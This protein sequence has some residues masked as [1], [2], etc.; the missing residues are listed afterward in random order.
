MRST[1]SEGPTTVAVNGSRKREQLG[2][3]LNPIDSKASRQ[4]Q[5]ARR[6]ADDAEHRILMRLLDAQRRALAAA[7]VEPEG[8]PCVCI[9]CAS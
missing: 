2:G 9:G 6:R 4:N 5:V 1:K 7:G 3:K 8:E